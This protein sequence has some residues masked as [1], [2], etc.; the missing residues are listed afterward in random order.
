MDVPQQ[1]HGTYDKYHSQDKALKLVYQDFYDLTF[2][3]LLAKDK[4]VIIHANSLQLLTTEIF[5]SKTV[6]SP[7]LMNDIF[8]F[9]ETP[10]NLRS[11]YTKAIIRKKTRS[12]CFSQVRESVFPCAQI[13]G[14]STK[15]YFF[16]EFKTEINTWAAEH[17]PFRLCKKHVRIVG[18]FAYNIFQLYFIQ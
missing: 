11:N 10:N 13:V 16:K 4:S 3:K 14:S 6:V 18:P 9:V 8:H 15:Y 7:K 12:Y 17:C 5:K 1:K 2:Q